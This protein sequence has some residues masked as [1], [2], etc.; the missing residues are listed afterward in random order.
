[1]LGCRAV[2]I[3]ASGFSAF[4]SINA[5]YAGIVSNLGLVLDEQVLPKCQRPARLCTDISTTYPPVLTKT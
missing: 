5:R 3:R 4:E 2:K 1:M